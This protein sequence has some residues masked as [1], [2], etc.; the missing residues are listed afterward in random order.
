VCRCVG[1]SVSLFLYM[2]LCLCVY[3][4]VCLC[5]FVCVCVSVCI[6]GTCSKI[7]YFPL[8]KMYAFVYCG[9]SCSKLAFLKTKKVKKKW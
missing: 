7:I 2:C 9:P 6:K 8:V 1:V 5:V 4:F 3:V